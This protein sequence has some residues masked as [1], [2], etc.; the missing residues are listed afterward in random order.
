MYTYIKYPDITHVYLHYDTNSK[1]TSVITNMLLLLPNT[2]INNIIS[3][4]PDC[5]KVQFTF[6]FISHYFR[7]KHNSQF[8]PKQE[9]TPGLQCDFRGAIN[10]LCHSNEALMSGTEIKILSNLQKINTEISPM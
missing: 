3:Q 6:T 5:L 10:Y 4:I 8:F 1:N 7:P 9:V 2:H